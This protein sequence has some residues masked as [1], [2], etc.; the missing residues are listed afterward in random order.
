MAEERIYIIPL[1]KHWM[2]KP[3]YKRSRAAIMAIKQFVAR[4]MRVEDRDIRK[5]KLD[6]YF[7][8]EVWFKGRS[9]P[10][11]KVKVKV[12]REGENVRVTFV[13]VPQQVKYKQAKNSKVHKPSDKPKEM[14]APKHTDKVEKA[15]EEARE[16]EE[17]KTEAQKKDEKE[18]EKAV[19]EAA[20]IDAKQDKKEK[21]H[22]P[23]ASNAGELAK[24]TERKAL[25]K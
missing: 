3:E 24:T 15:A 2:Q 17:N 19:A 16:N 8:N 21:K 13:D 12:F 4:H 5:V 1:R 7:N 23:K 20:Q 10:P 22:T 9:K 11:A 18:K 14:E 25:K 6:V